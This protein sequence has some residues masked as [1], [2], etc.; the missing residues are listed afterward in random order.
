MQGNDQEREDG[1]EPRESL[2]RLTQQRG[3]SVT[4]A[5]AWSL[6][7]LL[8]CSLSGHSA[9]CSWGLFRPIWERGPGSLP[10][11]RAKKK[12]P[13]GQHGALPRSRALLR[14]F[15]SPM[16]AAGKPMALCWAWGLN[17]TLIFPLVQRQHPTS[18]WLGLQERIQPMPAESYP[19]ERAGTPRGVEGGHPPVCS[20]HW[21]LGAPLLSSE[22]RARGILEE[23][24]AQLFLCASGF[25]PK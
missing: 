5:A 20:G 12:V 23:G 15:P 22:T 21:R 25:W 6:N 8:S 7:G 24:A 18:M 2:P 9:T 3:R 10:R 4:A 19:P 17:W 11:H 13:L 1:S 14:L 16:L